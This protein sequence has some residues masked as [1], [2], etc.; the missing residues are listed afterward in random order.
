MKRSTN[1]LE[2]KKTNRN[3][4]FRYVNSKEE[5]SM[6]EISTALQISTP[7]VLTIVNELKKSGV[8]REV[9]EL[10][11]TGGRKAKAMASVK[12]IKYAIGLDITK[13]HVGIVY[14]NLSQKSLR[15]E[16]I[17]KPFKHH[18]TYLK[19][20]TSIV[21]N[22]VEECNIPKERIVGIGMSLPAIIDEKRN[23]ITNSHALGLYNIPCEEMTSYMPSLCELI[24]D[25][26]A[27]ALTESNSRRTNGNMVYLSLS[28]T[29]GGAI[30]FQN[31]K[32][33]VDNADQW[34]IDSMNIYKG[35]NWRSGEFGHMVIHP[36]GEKCY[37]GKKGCVDAYCSALRLASHTGGELEKFFKEME[38]GNEKLRNIWNQ[39]LADL[40][41]AVDNLRMNFDC[42][43]I[44]G[45]YVGSNMEPYL[46]EFRKLVAEKNIFDYNGAYVYTCRHQSEASALGAAISQ[47]ERF[48]DTI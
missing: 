33:F 37:C 42:K 7:T 29:V 5:T 21:E 13:N 35:T 14:T 36:G 8:I 11:S 26:N 41:I 16:R 46:Q 25:A 45:G 18:S 28:N 34:D 40:A 9:G 2:V 1:N 39:Y 17:F 20:L 19:E 24:N 48:M 23:L 6:P 32:E 10:Q 22:F 43:V 31:E 3:K 47:I 27:A 4:V 38:E 30:V 15:H 12:D 44:L